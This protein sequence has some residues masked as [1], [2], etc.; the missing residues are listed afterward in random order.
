MDRTGGGRE[1]GGAPHGQR[2]GYGQGMGM[3]FVSP[4]CVRGA[5]VIS[6]NVV[7]RETR[8]KRLVGI[9]GL[10]LGD[11]SKRLPLA[12]LHVPRAREA[13]KCVGMRGLP[14]SETLDRRQV[15]RKAALLGF[16]LVSVGGLQQQVGA[17]VA[18]GGIVKNEKFGYTFEYPA[19]WKTVKKPVRG[20]SLP[21]HLCA[22]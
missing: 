4:L 1:P 15:F 10:R 5:A 12:A 22:H 14:M 8:A 2:G 13:S 9:V 18:P 7:C 6:A 11:A 21:V 16:A 20:Y 19:G 17:E 3:G